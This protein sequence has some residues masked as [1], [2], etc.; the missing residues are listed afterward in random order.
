MVRADGCR[1]SKILSLLGSA[2]DLHFLLHHRWLTPPY[3]VAKQSASE[4]NVT[5]RH[6]SFATMYQVVKGQVFSVQALK[7]RIS[8]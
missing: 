4:G 2:H 6:A 1:R 7:Y 5:A 3:P 8:N